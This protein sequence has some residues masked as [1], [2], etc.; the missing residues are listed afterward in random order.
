MV[1]DFQIRQP[2]IKI[3][4]AVASLTEKSQ[5]EK[6]ASEQPGQD[7]KDLQQTVENDI[8]SFL[9][10]DLLNGIKKS[11]KNAYKKYDWLLA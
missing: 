8:D 7:V 6:K 1:E 4:K 10:D 3:F 2:Q 9:T 5:E 11:Q